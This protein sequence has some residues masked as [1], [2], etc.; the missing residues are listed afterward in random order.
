M[1]GLTQLTHNPP[2]ASLGRPRPPIDCEKGRWL[3]SKS[4][5]PQSLPPFRQEVQN[6][7]LS[8]ER[9]LSVPAS[10]ENQPFTPDELLIVNHYVA[11]VSKM[12]GEC[13]TSW[14]KV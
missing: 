4:S 6:Y 10:R 7:L 2:T 8:C 1:I 3:M 9:L 14:P 11:E 13:S 12:V 5:R